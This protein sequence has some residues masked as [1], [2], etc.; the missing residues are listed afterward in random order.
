M[1]NLFLIILA[2]LVIFSQYITMR[3]IPGGAVSGVPHI[4]WVGTLSQDK[5]K[6][7]ERFRVWLKKRGLPDFDVRIDANNAQLAKIVIQA[8]AGI[9]GDVFDA[10]GSQVS[11]MKE[12]GLLHGFK[13]GELAKLSGVADSERFQAYLPETDREGLEYAVPF[14]ISVEGLL[15]N[16]SA[17][18]RAGLPPPPMVWDVKTFE[19]V[20]RAYM[21]K[22][23]KNP[24]RPDHFF[25]SP[26]NGALTSLYRSFGVS[27]YNETLTGSAIDRGSGL[28][29]LFALM[30]KWTYE[31]HILPTPSD[32]ASMSQENS[33]FMQPTWAMFSKG[34]IALHVGCRYILMPLREMKCSEDLGAVLFPHGSYPNSLSSARYLVAY[35]G[36]KKKE[37]A[38]AFA[39]YLR[40]EEYN[41]QIVEGGDNLPPIPS[42]M[43]EK[44]YLQAPGYTNEWK[45]NAGFREI[46]VR[47]AIGREDSPFALHINSERHFW[48]NFSAVF[49]RVT[50]PREAV[51]DIAAGVNKEIRDYVARH[52]DKKAAFEA[53]KKNQAKIDALRAAGKKI[54]LA[55]VD[56]VFLKKYYADT[57]M[58]E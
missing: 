5:P 41:R 25:C 48:K 6:Q 54:P 26:L 31:D 43:D 20:G 56:N 13:K 4:F 47:Y 12:M 16:R 39:A 23:N 37:M 50:P 3:V 42:Y 58:G 38:T 22:A 18:E 55:L 17:F 29:E 49:S 30:V 53:A 2:S 35:A 9:G 36:S 51:T 34:R 15:V 19:S 57:G 52:P 27:I 44:A 14:Q 40:S 33:G 10:Y 1:R 11:Y 7:V 8:T 46:A 24:E 21:K 45:L 28:A 32:M